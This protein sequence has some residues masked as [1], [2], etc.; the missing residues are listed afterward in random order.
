MTAAGVTAP[1]INAAL[2]QMNAAAGGGRLSIGGREQ[3]LRVLGAAVT[4]E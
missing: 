2:V 4:P 1:Q 3:T